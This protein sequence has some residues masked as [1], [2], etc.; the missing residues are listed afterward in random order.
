MNT[1][2]VLLSL[3]D[4]V[5]SYDKRSLFENLSVIIHKSDKAALVGKNGVGKTTLFKIFSQNLEVDKG[6]TWFNP[7]GRVSLMNQKNLIRENINLKTFILDINNKNRFF[8][9]FEIKN[10]FEKLKLNWNLNMNNL[11]GGQ[12][13]KVSLIKS[14]LNNPDLLLLDE[15]TNHLDIE[16]IK[17]LE[18]FLKNEFTGSFLVISHNRDFL[19][20]ITN[21]VFWV[22]RKKVKVSPK[23]FSFFDEWSS[24]LIKQEERELKNKKKLLDNENDWLAKGIKARRKRNERRKEDLLALRVS[25]ENEKSEFLKSIS[26]I[27]IPTVDDDK[28]S[29][30]TNILVNFIN[31]SKFFVSDN[32]EKKI[33]LN[34]FDFK[35]MRNEKIGI[36]GINGVGKSTFLKLVSGQIKTDFGKIKIR[37]NLN[38]SFFNQDAENFDDN[39]SIKKN[40][41]PSGGDYIKVGEKKIHICSYLKNFLFDPKSLDNKVLNLSGG[42]K[43]RLLLSKILANPQQIML[44]DEPTNDLDIE[45]IDMLIDFIQQYDGGVFISSHDVDFLNKTCKKFIFLDG[46]GGFKFSFDLEKDIRFIIE[47]PKT[48]FYKEKPSLKTTITKPQSIEKQIKKIL[49]KIEHKEKEIREL[50]E[51]IEKLQLESFNEEVYRSSLK[52]IKKAQFD[53]NQLEKEWVDLE[54]RNLY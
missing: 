18:N 25:Y 32:G 50:G 39:K 52:K 37:K 16:S 5:F 46:N 21:K 42:E 30:G 8:D 6:E 10:F 54:E 23:G 26:K 7:H 45:T 34:N 29:G 43:N 19:K 1:K 53:L 31:V 9:E 17:W 22:D 13:R 36:I 3:K 49:K 14:I 33:I 15:P 38:F 40:L 28:N 51:D 2:E 12:L 20:K 41:V 24:S 35:L 11:S 44:L 4:C 47:H 27:K 48:N